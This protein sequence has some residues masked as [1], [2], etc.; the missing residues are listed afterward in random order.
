MEQHFTVYTH[1]ASI[2]G[3]YTNQMKGLFENAIKQWPKLN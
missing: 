2:K 3:K 1:A